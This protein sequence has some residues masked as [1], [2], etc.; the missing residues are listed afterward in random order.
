MATLDPALTTAGPDVI[1]A[2]LDQLYAQRYRLNGQIAE[3]EEL[4]L[5]RSIEKRDGLWPTTGGTHAA[6]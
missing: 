3:I 1:R 5:R 4:L 2:R 6:R